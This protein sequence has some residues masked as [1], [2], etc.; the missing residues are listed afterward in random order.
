MVCDERNLPDS[1]VP[2]QRTRDGRQIKLQTTKNVRWAVR[3]GTNIYGNPVVA[4]GNLYLGNKRRFHVFAAGKKPRLLSEIR[5]GPTPVYSSP[6][7]A[8]GVLYVASQRYVWAVQQGLIG[9]QTE[10]AGN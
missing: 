3:V 1:F 2:G 8:K 10:P 7:A 4:D 6:I 9:S 5:L